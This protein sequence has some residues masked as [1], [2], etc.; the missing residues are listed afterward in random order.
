MFGY[1]VKDS[2]SGEL[3]FEQNLSKVRVIHAAIY[4]KNI[5]SKEQQR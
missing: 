3:I 5:L 2:L 1:M 4:G